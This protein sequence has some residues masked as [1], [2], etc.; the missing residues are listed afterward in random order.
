MSNHP[1]T[2]EAFRAALRR[3]AVTRPP[4]RPLTERV[5]F[6]LMRGIASTS[7]LLL[8]FLIPTGLLVAGVHFRNVV[9]A[10]LG[11]LVL[12]LASALTVMLV[13]GQRRLRGL[14][15][16]LAERTGLR[17]GETPDLLPGL[18]SFTLSGE[19]RGRFVWV[20]FENHAAP[21]VEGAGGGS[22][23]RRQRSRQA[24]VIRA[25]TTAPQAQRRF[26][27]VSQQELFDPSLVA[28]LTQAHRLDDVMLGDGAVG[29]RLDAAMT[30]E[31]LEAAHRS[32][33]LAVD[34]AERLE[35]PVDQEARASPAMAA[36][37]ACR[38]TMPFSARYPRAVCAACVAR[39]CDEGG[40][41]LDF[42]NTDL[43]GGLAV[44]YR[45][46]REPRES[47]LCF[48]DG[49]S[50]RAAEARFGGVVVQLCEEP[51]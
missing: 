5:L 45:D 35:R 2:D 4:A 40:R 39:A 24:L 36:C 8:G 49:L 1:P 38:A 48:I 12:G 27:P 11:L 43:G 14:L 51:R 7:V 17:L 42:F 6:W 25:R 26:G 44:V 28:W 21:G 37:P 3:G 29:F 47:P 16:P 23:L 32:I 33:G 34:L 19:L 41:P 31:G 10:V 50:C 22:G 15:A 30:S 13:A 20:A 9:P 46:T 18:A